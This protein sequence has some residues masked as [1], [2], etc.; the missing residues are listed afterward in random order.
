D[1]LTKRRET[2]RRL[3]AFMMDLE[4]NDTSEQKLGTTTTKTLDESIY[5]DRIERILQID[6]AALQV[7]KPR[8]GRMNSGIGHFSEEQRKHVLQNA[9][10]V[11][12]TFG[13]EFSNGGLQMQQMH[14]RLL[15]LETVED[16]NGMDTTSSAATPSIQDTQVVNGESSTPIPA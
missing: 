1:L 10:K 12:T 15:E 3:F 4:W 7:Y 11:L 2:L 5:G 8:K 6:Q 9:H 16:E 13:Y 14:A